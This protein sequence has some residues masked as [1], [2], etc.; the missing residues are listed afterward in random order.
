MDRY[1]QIF[2]EARV[3]QMLPQMIET[4]KQEGIQFSFGGK[5]ENGEK[6]QNDLINILFRAYFEQEQD[7]SDHQVLIR[8]AEL[9]GFNPNEIK[10]FLQ[11]D[12]YKKEVR[13]EINQS[14]EH[15]ISGVPHFRINDK[16]ELSGAQDPQ[17]FIQAFKKASVNV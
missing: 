9:V 15:G 4:G 1:K 14:Q 7:L 10:Q 13:E 11:S 2:G 3:K 5:V 16:I 17:Q 12:K 6:K 8:A